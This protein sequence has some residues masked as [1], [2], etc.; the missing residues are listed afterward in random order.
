MSYSINKILALFILAILMQ[1]CAE[2]ELID[3]AATAEVP[4]TIQMEKATGVEYMEDA[5]LESR[6]SPI[7]SFNTLNQA[8]ECTGLGAALASGQNTVYAPTDAAFAKLGLNASNICEALDTETL[9]NILLYH[10]TTS[11]LVS[12]SQRGCLEMANGN[13]AQIARKGHRLEINE[14]RITLLFNQR[15]GSALLRLYVIDNVLEVPTSNIVET[16]ASVSIFESLVAAVLAADPAIA[17]ALSDNDAVF[18]VFAPTND[19]F[20]DLVAALG[21]SS[22]E[23]VVAAVGV[24]A[25]STILLYHVV[26]ACAFSNHLSDGL[27]ITTLQG[28][29]LVVDLDNLSILDKTTDPAGLVVDLIDIRT[30]NGIVHTIDKVLLPQAILDVL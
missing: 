17:V 11:N 4:Q 22:L 16:A 14:S 21:A 13:V 2:N 29:E 19:A 26:D 5:E 3:A 6:T 1:N 8:L 9:S 20:N 24:D 18:T 7:Y 27:A 15:N 30:A 23:E 25:L 10:V 28:E 12:I